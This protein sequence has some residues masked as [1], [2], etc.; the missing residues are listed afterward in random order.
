MSS[1]IKQA[2]ERRTKLKLHHN[3]NSI[4]VEPY[5]FGIDAN[6]ESLLLCWQTDGLE[7]HEKGDGWKVIPLAELM[8]I[9]P[10]NVPCGQIQSGYIR[11]H[12]AFDTVLLQV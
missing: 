6:G 11:N 10:V 4:V 8:S 9:E 12:P 1:I 3:G 5:A 7:S 2:I